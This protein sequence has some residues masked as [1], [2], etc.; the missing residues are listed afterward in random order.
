MQG[1]GMTE[2]SPV[3]TLLNLQSHHTA[4]S[5]E[6]AQW[7]IKAKQGYPL[8]GVEMRIVDEGGTIYYLG[9]A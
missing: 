5:R 2:T 3:G 9:T 1:W 4:Q 7:D 8:A 6:H